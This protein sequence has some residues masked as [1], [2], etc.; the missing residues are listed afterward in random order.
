MLNFPS[1]KHVICIITIHQ[2]YGFLIAN[3]ILQI[4]KTETQKQSGHQSEGEE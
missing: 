4:K 1:T 3:P 2:L